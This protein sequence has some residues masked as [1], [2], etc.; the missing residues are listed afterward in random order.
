MTILRISEGQPAEFVASIPW[1]KPNIGEK[2]LKGLFGT[3]A[4]GHSYKDCQE[5]VAYCVIWGDSGAGCTYAQGELA[6]S[7]VRGLG[8]SVLLKDS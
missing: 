1:P 6:W 7:E 2:G 4:C 3:I 5:H 8:F